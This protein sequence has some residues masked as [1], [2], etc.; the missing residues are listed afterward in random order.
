MNLKV[1]ILALS[2]IARWGV[3][4]SFGA[5]ADSGDA[6]SEDHLIGITDGAIAAGAYGDATY[7]GVLF[8]QDWSWTPGAAIFLNGQNLSQISPGAGFVAQIGLAITSKSIF[9]NISK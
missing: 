8:N 4:N 9:I 2:A 3:V 5:Q 6:V 1:Q 7:S